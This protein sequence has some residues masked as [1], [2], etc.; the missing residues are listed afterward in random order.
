MNCKEYILKA[1]HPFFISF[2][3]EETLQDIPAAMNQ[4]PDT[5]YTV[6]KDDYSAWERSMDVEPNFDILPDGTTASGLRGPQGKRNTWDGEKFDSKWEYAFYRYHKEI[7]G[8]IITRNHDE[9]IPYYDESGKLRK[10]Y[11]DFIVNSQP[12]EVK[13]LFRESDLL[14]Q[15]A[16][17]G[18]VVFVTGDDIKPMMKILDEKIPGW[19][20]DCIEI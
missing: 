5:S 8:D 17:S 15:Q 10:F 20:T 9:W 16:S 14:K 4:K 1:H 2:D 3:D 19:R 11:Y 12:H 7:C 13:G 6:T 18:I